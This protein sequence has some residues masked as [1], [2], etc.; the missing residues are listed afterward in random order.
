MRTR[1]LTKT[2]RHDLCMCHAPCVTCRGD[3]PCQVLQSRPELCPSFGHPSFVHPHPGLSQS[4]LPEA[5]CPGRPGSA[6][7]RTAKLE[8]G[9]GAGPQLQLL[10]YLVIFAGFVQ[11][12][13]ENLRTGLP[14]SVFWTMVPQLGRFRPHD[15]D[16]CWLEFGEINRSLANSRPKLTKYAQQMAMFGPRWPNIWQSS[17]E[18]GRPICRTS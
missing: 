4:R 18:F 12:L 13:F 14:T 17:G 1:E 16:R 7:S 8:G 5:P 6:L 11:V 2:P 15:T 10:L 3:G 9:L